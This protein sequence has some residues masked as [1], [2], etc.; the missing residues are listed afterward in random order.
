LEAVCWE[1]AAQDLA[2]PLRGLPYSRARLVKADEEVGFNTTLHEAHRLNSPD[3]MLASQGDLLERAKEESATQGGKR[4][5]QRSGAQDEDASAA[6][7]HFDLA[8]LA[9]TLFKYDPNSLLHGVFLEKLDGRARLQRTL[10]CFIEASEVAPATSGGV[11]NDRI[12]P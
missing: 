3:F 8:R 10:S 9:R 4:Q 5:R 6:V 2:E 11:K 12:S 7:L 1:V